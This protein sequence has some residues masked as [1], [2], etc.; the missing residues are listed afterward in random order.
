MTAQIVR[1]PFMSVM[2]AREIVSNPDLH[3][4]ASVLDACEMLAIC[5]GWE[6]RQRAKTLHAQ[7]VSRAVCE[8]NAAG[9]RRARIGALIEGAVG[10]ACLFGLLY[11]FLLFTP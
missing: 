9:R 8:I 7:I 3:D 4:E 11:L 5:G 2:E 6:D 1:F 10:A